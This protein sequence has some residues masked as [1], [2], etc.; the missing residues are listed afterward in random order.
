MLR[1]IL[2][3]FATRNVRDGMEKDHGKELHAGKASLRTRTGWR[4]FF[5]NLSAPL[6]HMI[7]L[8]KRSKIIRTGDFSPINVFGGTWYWYANFSSL[9]TDHF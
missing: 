4:A 8:E 5:Q 3:E 9:Y 1:N 7:V 2:A 6:V